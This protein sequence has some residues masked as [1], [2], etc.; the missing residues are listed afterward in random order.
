MHHLDD[1]VI[2]DERVEKKKHV[3][4]MLAGRGEQM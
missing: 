2:Q 3:G 4:T 1:D